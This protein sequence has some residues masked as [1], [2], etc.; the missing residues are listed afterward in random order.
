MRW[1]RE[2]SEKHGQENLVRLEATGLTFRAFLDEV[3]VAPFIAEK[4]LVFVAGI[5]RFSKEEVQSLTH[6]MHPACIAVFMDPKP[7]KRLSGWKELQKLATAKDFPR[8]RGKALDAWITE[9]LQTLGAT[10]SPSAQSELL[11]SVGEDQDLLRSELRKLAVFAGTRTIEQSDIRLL[12]IP[13]GDQ[14]IWMLL[15]L[16]AAGKEKQAV[17]VA[18][19]LMDRGTAPMQLWGMLLWM[20]ENIGTTTAAVSEKQTNPQKI[21]QMGVPFGSVRTL[22]PLAQRISPQKLRSF[23]DQ[24][25]RDDIDLKTGG[26][27]ATAEAPEEIEAL[28]DRLILGCGALTILQSPSIIPPCSSCL[29]FRTSVRVPAVPHVSSCDPHR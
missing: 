19:T 20:L 29:R 7:D 15:N 3:S 12:V 5:P 1:I 25:I 26:Y 22:L 6:H 23:L 27:R 28:I 2:F 8:I 21:A 4:R 11:A 9:E 17:R 10:M 13:S 24:I 14:E 16:I 18:Q